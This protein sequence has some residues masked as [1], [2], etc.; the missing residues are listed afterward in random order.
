MQREVSLVLV[1]PFSDSS[2]DKTLL[3]F[4]S[5]S[6][7]PNGLWKPEAFGYTVVIGSIPN[8]QHWLLM[9]CYSVILLIASFWNSSLAHTLLAHVIH[10]MSMWG[11]FRSFLEVAVERALVPSAIPRILLHHLLNVPLAVAV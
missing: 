7:T 5:Q 8:L 11:S 9:T 2:T 1:S 3:D 6:H 10:E 4:V